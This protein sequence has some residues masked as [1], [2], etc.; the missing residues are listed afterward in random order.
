MITKRSWRSASRPLLVSLATGMALLPISRR[1]AAAALATAGVVLAFFRDPHRRVEP[2][3]NFVYAAADGTVT[4]VGV[5][6][7]PW[8][9]ER[10]ALRIATYLSLRDVHVNRS[11]IAGTVTAIEER[12]GSFSPAFTVNA[13]AR[14]RQ[15]RISMEGPSG[16]AVVV[17][18]A[19]LLARRISRWVDVG[20]SLAAGQRI[21]L[22]HF[23]SRTDVLLP[24]ARAVPLVRRGDRVRAGVTPVAVY[25]D[26]RGG[27]T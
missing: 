17:Q 11:P 26:R 22:I 13:G 27:D 2:D 19:G 5:E 3:P 6:P 10:D 9:G 14:N 20:D 7:A 25:R 15:N 23:G 12:A 4:A 18:V 1:G 16:P 21:G 8:A 24:A